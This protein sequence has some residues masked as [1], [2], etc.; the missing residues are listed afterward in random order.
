[1]ELD[2]VKSLCFPSRI[3]QINAGSI[4]SQTPDD[5]GCCELKVL[6]RRIGGQFYEVVNAKGQTP[7]KFVLE[8]KKECL[9]GGLKVDGAGFVD[10]FVGFQVGEQGVAGGGIEVEH[11]EGAAAD[12]V[13]AE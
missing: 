13:A 11:A 7:C 4:K 1:M 6:T 8:L 10:A 9:W 5:F 3:S 12:F 2:K